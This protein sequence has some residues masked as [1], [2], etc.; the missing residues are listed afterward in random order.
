M[1]KGLKLLFIFAFA[2]QATRV[3]GQIRCPFCVNNLRSQGTPGPTSSRNKWFVEQGVTCNQAYL[4][5]LTSPQRCEFIRSNYQDICCFGDNDATP[6]PQAVPTVSPKP[7]P[8][9]STTCVPDLL[10]C[11]AGGRPCCGTNSMCTNFPDASGAEANRLCIPDPGVSGNSRTDNFQF[12]SLKQFDCPPG[13]KRSEQDICI[14][15]S[16]TLSPVAR[17]RLNRGVR[18]NEKK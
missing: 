2:D 16:P 17:R 9:P 1:M 4:Q 14:T 5:A 7:S 8:A 13:Q 15:L 3:E 10:D 12:K 11:T 18:G 6:T